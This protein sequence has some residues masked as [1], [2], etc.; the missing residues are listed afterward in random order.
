MFPWKQQAE[1]SP[2][3]LVHVSSLRHHVLLLSAE[4]PLPI[5]LP[6]TS[7]S[8]W[9]RMIGCQM[10]SQIKVMVL[11]LTQ[12]I[13]V[14]RSM[15]RI[16]SY[17]LADFPLTNVHCTD[18]HHYHHQGET[19]APL[20][21]I[22]MMNLIQSWVM[23]PLLQQLLAQVVHYPGA[24]NLVSKSLLNI[25]M[26]QGKGAPQTILGYNKVPRALGVL[27]VGLI[28][29][30][31]M[32]VQ[33]LSGRCHQEDHWKLIRPRAYIQVQTSS[34]K[35]K[36]LVNYSTLVWISSGGARTSLLPSLPH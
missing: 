25:C 5:H 10:G 20:Y 24:I 13:I 36:A 33:C 23:C 27:R 32:A 18:H 21:S 35:V 34:Q 17:F 14:G 26:M 3:W 19:L 9:E 22:I 1:E 15:M 16:M 6:T 11:K 30:L 4:T 2:A 29:Q 8:V 28:Q 7:I 12:K 31:G